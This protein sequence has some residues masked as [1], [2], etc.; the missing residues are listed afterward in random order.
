MKPTGKFSL[1]LDALTAFAIV[2]IVLVSVA[3]SAMSLIFRPDREPW[4]VALDVVILVM[5]VVLVFIATKVLR[6]ALKNLDAEEAERLLAANVDDKGRP[7]NAADVTINPDGSLTA[8]KPY[9]DPT[10]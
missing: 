6:R 2:A 8:G 1:I 9:H 10:V 5:F 3:T 4:R 7:L